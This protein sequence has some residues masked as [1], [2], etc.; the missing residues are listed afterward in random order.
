MDSTITYDVLYELLRKEKYSTE[1]QK[2]DQNLFKDVIRYLDEKESI[3]ESQRSKDS[4]F[5][6]EIQKTQIQLGNARKVLKEL[7]ER[8]ENKLIQLALFSSRMNE[9]PDLSALL[10]E[11][12]YL[13]NEILKILNSGRESILFNVLQ[14][15]LPVLEKEKPKELKTVAEETK[16]IRFLH[17]VPKFVGTD[18]N[19]YG[20]FESE[21]LAN[22]PSRIAGVLIEKERA[23]EISHENA[24]KA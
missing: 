14:K 8:R 20:P 2:V 22:L 19:I 17:A 1:L 15:K 18:L 5:S 12:R 13:Y 23:E 24:E 10:P 4:I 11:E 21:D 16:L 6:S 9:K 7:Y 3:I